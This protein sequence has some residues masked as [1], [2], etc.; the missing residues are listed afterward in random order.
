MIKKK[1][2]I[3]II[4]G[5]AAGLMAAVTAGKVSGSSSIALLEKNPQLGKKLLATGNGRCN[6][7]H[8]S[9][10]DSPIILDFFHHLGIVTYAD[11]EGRIYPCS[12]QSKDVVGALS[13]SLESLPVEVI[14][15]HE[16]K[17]IFP[18]NQGFLVDHQFQC[19]KLL[20]A[21]GGKAGP[22][23]GTIGQGYAWA[24]KLGHTVEKTFPILT[25]IEAFV[26]GIKGVR[27]RGEITL[28]KR[29][30]SNEEILYRERGEIQ[31]TGEGLSGICVFNA[32][33]FLVLDQG[34]S[35][36]DY[37]LIVDFCP[38]YTLEELEEELNFR[39]DRQLDPT[40]SLVP[41]EVG[42]WLLKESRGEK[43]LSHQLKAKEIVIEGA[44]GWKAAQ[45]TKGG[46]SLK[47]IDTTTME[48]K[49]HKGL[50]FA[51]EVL[52]FD[53]FCG[54]FNLEFAWESGYKAGR[55]MVD[56]SNS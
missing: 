52:D 43:L 56:V 26:G 51:G 9:C 5:G 12:R 8:D 14:S 42:Q 55:S 17:E 27:T 28:I 4:G 25:P 47:E 21:S 46:V 29:K 49:I 41:E 7:S 48:S 35:F 50:Y 36:S 18:V 3:I 1:Y 2:D 37:R 16:V 38:Q 10:K 24:K 44:K 54:G 13:R 6:L 31:F 40:R 53:G 45:C 11:E 34:T 33:R 22:Q 23:F 39:R 20:I 30:G 32:S 15:D 19:E